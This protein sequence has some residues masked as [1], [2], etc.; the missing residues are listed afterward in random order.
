MGGI[1]EPSVYMH[2]CGSYLK[3]WMWLYVGGRG[4]LVVLGG[5]YILILGAFFHL[6]EN[7]TL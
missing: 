4:M 5:W 2:F 1:N 3:G 6:L 7:F